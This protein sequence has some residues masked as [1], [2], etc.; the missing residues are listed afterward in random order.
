MAPGQPVWSTRR[1]TP[2]AEAAWKCGIAYACLRKIAVAMSSIPLSVFSGDQEQDLE[3]GNLAW[4]LKHPN[5]LAPGSLFLEELIGFYH[6]AGNAYVMSVPETGPVEELWILH[7][8]NV[9]PVPGTS[10]LSGYLFTAPGNSAGKL[11]TVDPVTQLGQVGH[12][13][14]WNYDVN[15]EQSLLGRPLIGPALIA[16]D[17]F[18]AGSEFNLSLMQNAGVPGG[19]L[20]VPAETTLTES[21]R[22]RMKADWQ[23]RRGGPKNAGR[24]LIMEGG[25]KYERMGNN[26]VELAWLESRNQVAREISLVLG[27][28]PML[29]GIPGDNTYSNYQEARRAFFTDTII[30]L[31]N[32]WLSLLNTWL[33]PRWEGEKLEIRYD[34][35]KLDAFS[36]EVAKKWSAANGAAWLTLDEKRELCGYEPLEIEGESNVVFMSAALV[37]LREGAHDPDPDPTPEEGTEKK[38]EKKKPEKKPAPRASA[39]SLVVGDQ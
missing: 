22:T 19:I 26:P 5:P 33:C 12:W 13:R 4:L 20:T 31:T 34:A 6:L 9:K 7:P 2:Q 10:G 27:V 37:P 32:N 16:I 30:P 38:P 21:Q 17:M 18:N 14:T 24:V 29:L 39:K 1:F 3:P 11:Y 15:A 35:A 23:E 28:P 8:E 25:M 36:D